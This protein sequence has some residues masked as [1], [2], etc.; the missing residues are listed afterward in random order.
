MMNMKMMMEDNDGENNRI[1]HDDPYWEEVFEPDLF[2]EDN[3]PLGHP[4]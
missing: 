2:D 4:W 1:D 3:N